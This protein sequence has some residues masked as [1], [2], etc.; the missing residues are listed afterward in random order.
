MK[1]KLSLATC[2]PHRA[3]RAPASPIRAPAVPIDPPPLQ[4]GAG[5]ASACCRSTPS[6]V[7]VRAHYMPL[8]SRLGAYPMAMLDDAATPAQAAAVRILG[9]RGVVPAARH[10]AADGSGSMHR[11]PSAA[12]SEIYSGLAQNSA[13]RT[14]RPGRPRWSGGFLSGGPLAASD[15]DGA[16]A[17]RAAGG[18]GADG[19]HGA[20]NGCSGPDASPHASASRGFERHLRPARPGHPETGGP[21]RCPCPRRGRRRPPRSC[22][23]RRRIARSASPRWATCATISASPAT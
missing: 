15:I 3:G 20:S 5:T 6:R 14:R 17:A 21:R 23:A 7:A 19:K 1:D 13:A 4:Q 8:F 2:A 10:L 12:R 11:G 16:S 18:A 9:A 22:C